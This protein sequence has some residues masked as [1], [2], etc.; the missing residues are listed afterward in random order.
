MSSTPVKFLLVLCPLVF[1]LHFIYQLSL[2]SL[3]SRLLFLFNQCCYNL[4]PDFQFLL[5]FLQPPN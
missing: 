1:Y 2:L 3:S 4:K 5:I